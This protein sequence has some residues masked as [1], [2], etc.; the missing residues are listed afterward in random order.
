[1]VAFRA[2]ER[3]NSRKTT[4]KGG[5]GSGGQVCGRFAGS[6]MVWLLGHLHRH[7][8]GM[9]PCYGLLRDSGAVFPDA[10]FGCASGVTMFPSGLF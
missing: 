5:T 1:M 10:A 9:V 4:F 7:T 3:Y 2:P 6:K 8:F